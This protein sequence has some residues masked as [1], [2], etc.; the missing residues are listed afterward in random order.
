MR[1][2]ILPRPVNCSRSA[3]DQ[4]TKKRSGK[5]TAAPLGQT[6]IGSYLLRQETT[7]SLV[8]ACK[9]WPQL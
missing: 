4:A 8:I 5:K 6:E 9:S 7:S 3:P 1:K 2:S